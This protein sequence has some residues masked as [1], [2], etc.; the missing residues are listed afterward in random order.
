M[1]NGIQPTDTLTLTETPTEAGGTTTILVVLPA[2]TSDD[3]VHATLLPGSTGIAEIP[4]PEDGQPDSIF[5]VPGAPKPTS[6]STVTITRIPDGLPQPA[7]ATLLPGPPPVPGG[8]VT[9][10]YVPG[11]GEEFAKPSDWTCAC[12]TAS[13]QVVT[14]TRQPEPGPT[15]ESKLPDGNLTTVPASKFPCSSDDKNPCKGSQ[16]QPWYSFTVGWTADFP[17]PGPP[18]PF[19]TTSNFETDTILTLTDDLYQAEHFKVTMDEEVIGE[20]HE[21]GWKNDKIYCGK[22]ADECMAKGWSH[23][24]FLIPKGKHDLGF[25]WTEG[26]YQTEAGGNWWYGAGQH[27]LCTRR[28]M[29]STDLPADLHDERSSDSLSQI[30]RVLQNIEGKLD[31]YDERFHRLEASRELDTQ[32]DHDEDKEAESMRSVEG[33]H[34]HPPSPTQ[35]QTTLQDSKTDPKIYYTEWDTNH[36][37]EALPQDL[38]TEWETHGA[39]VDQIFDLRLSVA[40]EKR[41]GSC[42]QMPDDDRLPLKFF[43]ANI[44]KTFMQSG[45]PMRNLYK[46]KKPFEKDLAFLCDFDDKLRSHKGNDFVA[47]DFD[48]FNN[49]RIYRLG[50]EAI[51]SDLLVRLEGAQEA[52]WSR[53]IL[54][55]GAATGGSINPERKRPEQPI[56]YF[57]RNDRISGVWDHISTHLQLKARGTTTNPYATSPWTGFHTTFYEILETADPIENE[58][59]RHGPL[60]DHPLGWQFRKCAYTLYSPLSAFETSN[61]SRLGEH[62]RFWTILILSPSGFFKDGSRAFPTQELGV[63]QSQALGHCFGRLSRV[64]AE[65]NLIGHGLERISERWTDFQTYFD[66]ILHGGDS[67][68]NPSEHDNLLFDDGAFSRS[69]KYFWVIECLS[70]FDICISD[71]LTQW[72]LYKAARIPLAHDALTKLDRV[73]LSFAERH[74]TVL[75][76][77]RDTFRQKLAATKALRDALFNASAVIESRASTRL[78]EHVKLLTFVSIFFLPLAF[79]TSLWSVND[80]FSSSVLTYVI[81]LVALTTYSVMFN[82]DSLAQGFGRVYDIKK[83]KVVRAMKRDRNETWKLRGKRFEVFRPKSEN[84]E[85]SEWYIPLYAMMH[86]GALLGLIN[87]SSTSARTRHSQ[88]D[89]TQHKWSRMFSRRRNKDEE[90]EPPDEGWVM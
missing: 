49:S 53:I 63:G 83:K 16:V 18:K 25:Q 85:P 11:A 61:N 64:G 29:A 65:M 8:D 76:N 50:T 77:Q 55:Q 41:L 27:A 42:W 40:M 7:K 19:Y 14:V 5:T 67:L 84:P 21:N 35:V 2:S 80:K 51:G 88:K 33:W 15:V 28:L 57:T 75:Q 59:W 26:K 78:G 45:V 13:A 10:I 89:A 60:Y 34:T 23:G 46:A 87:D 82:I 4:K 32:Y 44:L 73:Q 68:M 39:K 3:A 62:S 9:S 38:Y 17:R 48:T 86:P 58:L 90:K 71:N 72:E 6:Q 24:S 12:A 56:P 66:Y 20:T 43:R 81:I 22:N 52:P 70:E 74:C 37:I 79:T 31:S 1:G 36:F 47:V 54:Y 69:R 30:L